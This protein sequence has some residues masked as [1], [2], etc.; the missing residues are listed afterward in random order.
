VQS[1]D[2]SSSTQ[3]QGHV[4]D[5]ESEA[6]SDDAG[7]LYQS[8]ESLYQPPG[9]SNSED[10]VSPAATDGLGNIGNLLSSRIEGVSA[11]QMTTPLHWC[12]SCD[13][14]TKC[15]TEKNKGVLR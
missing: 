14:R 9:D 1:G 3:V 4:A 13:T 15:A 11:A 2:A 8:P 12:A 7:S 10:Y 6:G 5:S